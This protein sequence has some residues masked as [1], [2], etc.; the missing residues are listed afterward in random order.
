MNLVGNRIIFGWD[1]ISSTGND[2]FV[3][4]F[5]ELFRASTSL[6]FV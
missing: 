6:K 1:F 5:S 2:V 4:A 3:S